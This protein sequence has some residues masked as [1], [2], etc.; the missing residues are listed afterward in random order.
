MLNSFLKFV[1]TESESGIFLFFV[2]FFKLLISA[3]P[4]VTVMR[5][6]YLWVARSQSWRTT[7]FT[8]TTPA[9]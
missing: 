8:A 4:T 9:L 7:E 1:R 2:Y 6:F 5:I 3:V